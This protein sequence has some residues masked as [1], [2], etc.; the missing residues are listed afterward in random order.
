MDNLIGLGY[1]WQDTK[2]YYAIG[3]KNGNIENSNFMIQLPNDNWVEVN[4][5]TEN[6]KEIYDNIYKDGILKYELETF[7]YDGTCV[8][9]YYR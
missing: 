7:N 6:L 1:K 9:K 4:G 3:L 8:I 2:I 5:E